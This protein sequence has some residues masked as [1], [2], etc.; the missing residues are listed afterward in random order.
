MEG[1]VVSVAV[2]VDVDVVVAV[3]APPF[4]LLNSPFLSN[5]PLTP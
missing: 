1:V 3:A 5:Q 2:D 4:T